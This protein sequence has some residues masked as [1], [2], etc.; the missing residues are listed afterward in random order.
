MENL[1][2]TVKEIDIRTEKQDLI[3]NLQTIFLSLK[4]EELHLLE[5]ILKTQEVKKEN[6]A[7]IKSFMNKC[8][9]VGYVVSKETI[10]RNVEMTFNNEHKPIEK[11]TE[12]ID[13][14]IAYSKR[15]KTA[16]KLQDLSTKIIKEGFTPDVKLKIN[17]ILQSDTIISGYKNITSKDFLEKCKGE[18]QNQ[19]YISTCVRELDKKICGI[20]KGKITSILGATGCLKS[21]MATNIAYAA[22]LQGLN[23][24]Y[25]SLEMVKYNVLSNLL[26]RHSNQDKFKGKIEHRYMKEY[27][28][29]EIEIEYL[30]KV[31][32]PDYYKLPRKS[33]HS[34]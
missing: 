11:V 29:R 28:L 8:E 13:E 34:R 14:Y 2:E 20:P 33:L 26:S 32:M 18:C 17:K 4:F 19:S 16:E 6:K 3:P 23:T 15:E 30:E 7:I 21:T 27:R 9:E 10:Q 1:E 12:Y 24:L 25:L 22:Q 31:I 5:K